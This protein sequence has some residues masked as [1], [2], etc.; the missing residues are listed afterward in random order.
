VTIG[1]L[2]GP[3]LAVVRAARAAWKT[4]RSPTPR[5]RLDLP[6]PPGDPS[7]RALDIVPNSDL[8]QVVFTLTLFNQGRSPARHWRVRFVTPDTR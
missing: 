1:E 7:R 4:L 8:W 2:V 5:L 6:A 3:L